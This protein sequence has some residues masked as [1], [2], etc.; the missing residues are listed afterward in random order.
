[1]TPKKTPKKPPAKKAPVKR[2]VEDRPKLVA[3][4]FARMAQGSSLRSACE[5]EG[6]KVPTVMLWIN[7]DAALADQYAR[8]MLARADAKFEELDDVSEE[9][10]RAGSAVEVQGLR[11]KADNIKWQI[12]RMNARKY[13]DKLALGGADDLP[14]LKTMDDAALDAKIRELMEK[15]G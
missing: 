1:V 7:E 8:A 12:A 11:L 15:A 14:P 3:P 6:L 9:A 4:V 2:P 13:G 5:A 10:T